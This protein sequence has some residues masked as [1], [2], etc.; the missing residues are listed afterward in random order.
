MVLIV[1][2]SDH[3][4]PFAFLMTC[5]V[6]WFIYFRREWREVWLQVKIYF[7][8]LETVRR[9]QILRYTQEDLIGMLFTPDGRQSETLVQLLIADEICVRQRFRL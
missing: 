2:V 5:K 8:S 7:E 1:P 9:E 4:L 3:P 6:D